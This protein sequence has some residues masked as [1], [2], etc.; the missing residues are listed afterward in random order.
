LENLPTPSVVDRFE[1]FMLHLKRDLSVWRKQPV[2]VPPTVWANRGR[3]HDGRLQ[4]R[5]QMLAD[6]LGPSLLKQFN[7]ANLYDLALYCRT[8]YLYAL[9]RRESL[10]QAA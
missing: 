10:Q 3:S 4:E 7:A 8:A 5:L 1:G 9:R 2:E 6:M